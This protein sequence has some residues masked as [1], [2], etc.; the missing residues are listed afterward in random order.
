MAGYSSEGAE[1]GRASPRKSHDDEGNIVRLTSRR[2]PYGAS[3][4]G[5]HLVGGSAAHCNSG[6]R[7]ATPAPDLS[8]SCAK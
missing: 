5:L 2:S 8:R 4:P 1:I 3:A 6:R 7:K